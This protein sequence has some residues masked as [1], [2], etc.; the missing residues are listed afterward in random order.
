MDIPA[1]FAVFCY[2]SQAAET[3]LAM[4]KTSDVVVV[5]ANL[6]DTGFIY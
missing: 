4:A 6:Q 1:E 5:F 2:S 3:I